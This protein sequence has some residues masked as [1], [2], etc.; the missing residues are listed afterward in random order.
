MSAT[1]AGDPGR[2]SVA[3]RHAACRG[4]GVCVGLAPE[5][6]DVDDSGRSRPRADT[7]DAD[8]AVLD[9]AHACPLEAIVVTDRATGRQ[10]APPD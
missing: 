7:I 8:E 3:V 1:P 5:H 4:S 10:L 6:F 9:A 2:W